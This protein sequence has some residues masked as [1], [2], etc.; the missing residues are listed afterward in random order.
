M[1]RVTIIFTNTQSNRPLSTSPLDDSL[2]EVM[3][4]SD[5]MLLKVVDTV[6]PGTADFSLQHD[7]DSVVDRISAPGLTVRSTIIG[8]ERQ[9]GVTG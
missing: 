8:Y 5:K 1:L 4:L 2:V 7:P 6:D 9:D 3:S